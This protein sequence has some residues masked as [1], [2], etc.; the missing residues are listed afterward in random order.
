MVPDTAVELG[1]R[2]LSGAVT[3]LG[4]IPAANSVMTVDQFLE[5]NL[6]SQM[7]SHGASAR[8]LP[9]KQVAELLAEQRRA[10]AERYGI[11]F[12]GNERLADV[13]HRTITARVQDLLG[14]YARF[15]PILSAAA[16]FFAFKAFTFPLYFIALAATAVLIKLLLAFRILKKGTE[17]IE[18]ERISLA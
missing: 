12:Q 2:V 17:K 1:L 11:S 13:L 7:Q 6:R 3:D 4:K 8:E 14:P 16:F 9:Q 18:V 15:L 5:E 10:L